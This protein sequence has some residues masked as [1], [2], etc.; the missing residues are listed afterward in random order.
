MTNE[1]D[2]E[3][4]PLFGGKVTIEDTE[5]LLNVLEDTAEDGGR[6]GDVS[7]MSFSGKTGEYK[8]GVDAR[9]PGKDEPFLVAIT[10]FEL[11]WMCWKGGK[12]KAKR[13]ASISQ[14]KIPE[15]DS[16]EFGPFDSGKGEGWS[17]ARGITVRS[18]ETGEQCYFTNNSKSGV[19]VMSDLQR[20]VVGRMKSGQPCWP[21]VTFGKEKFEAGGFTNSKPIMEP[22]AWLNVDDVNKL[23]DPDVDPMS[24]LDDVEDEVEAAPEPRKRRKL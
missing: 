13:M 6:Q 10:M 18:M 5:A 21:V 2:N 19:A 17:K 24:L 16:E 4:V 20:E 11:G 9:E 12:P 7:F 15:P 14:P 1:T 22:I 3:I 23:G 8:I